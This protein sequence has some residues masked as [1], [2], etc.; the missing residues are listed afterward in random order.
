MF[1][2][3]SASCHSNV[4]SFSS[5]TPS[6]LLVRSACLSLTPVSVTV[7]QT[8]L[9]ACLQFAAPCR[10]TMVTDS[11]YGETWAGIFKLCGISFDLRGPRVGVVELLCFRTQDCMQSG[12]AP[13]HAWI[14]K[15]GQLQNVHQVQ[16]MSFDIC[17]PSTCTLH[18]QR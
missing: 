7:H 11:F 9:C 2:I 3:T 10:N 17:H 18:H 8:V 14:V 16:W 1:Y 15:S 4:D 13:D 5:F 12:C 6:P